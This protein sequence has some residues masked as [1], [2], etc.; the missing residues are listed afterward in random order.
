MRVG[1]ERRAWMSIVSLLTI[2]VG[3]TSA[4]GIAYGALIGGIAVYIDV[5]VSRVCAAIDGKGP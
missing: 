5:M 2:V 4:W 1:S 3:A